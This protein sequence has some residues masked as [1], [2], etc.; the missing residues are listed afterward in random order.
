MSAGAEVEFGAWRDQVAAM[1][2]AE[3]ISIVREVRILPETP[4]TQDSAWTLSG[5]EPG[6]LVVADRQTNGRGRLGRTWLH[7]PGAGLAMTLTLEASRTPMERLSLV[8]G[9]AAAMGIE[10]SAGVPPLGLRWPNDVV[11]RGKRGRKIAGVLVE[12]RERLAMIG[13]GVNVVQQ[14][15]DFPDDLRERAMSVAMLP[16]ARRPDRREVLAAVLRRL[17]A[18]LR[19]D[20]DA[21]PQWASRDVLAGTDRVFMHAGRTVSGRVIGVD[22]LNAITVET[23]AGERISLPALTTSLIHGG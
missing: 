21:I 22:P 2:R 17:D 3:S 4:S 16:G 12:R 23:P 8:V 13:I 15:A 5:G 9:I 14:S 18:L 11:E 10:D 6:M 7:K 1:V 19:A 20:S